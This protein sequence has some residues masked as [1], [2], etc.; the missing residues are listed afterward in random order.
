MDDL[1]QQGIT[2]YKAGKREEAR[3]IFST[4]V[5]QNPD[6]E[7]A[8]GWMTSVCNT[9][10]ERIHCLKQVVRINPRN[11]K[12]RQYLSQLLA[13][14]TSE[15]ALSPISSVPLSPTP[16]GLKAKS[17]NSS[18]THTQLFT[19]LGLAIM[20]F[21]I[22]G[23]AFLYLFSEED[24]VV[25]VA[26]PTG[27]VATSNNTTSLPTQILPTATLIPTYV[28]AP[29][30]T[31][32]PSPTSFVVATLVPP[33]PESQP[34]QSNPVNPP[35]VSSGSDCSSQLN[36]SAAM[37]Q[38][39]LDAIDYVHAPLIGL[40]K[41]WIDEAAGNRDAVGMVEAQRKLDNEQAQVDAEKSAENKRYKAEKASIN[42]SCQ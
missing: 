24:H 5:K 19:L 36:Y 25:T 42:A 1:L 13:P 27:F 11:E 34:A 18:F 31:P 9:D 15:L 28:Y 12:A 3:R 32:F 21:F 14:L 35:S 20:V 22:F 6:S 37:H 23:F 16:S 29:T 38:Y 40:Y 39:Y 41:S 30:W 7:R 17:R 4:I 26:S 10:Q 8:W 2:A 33:K